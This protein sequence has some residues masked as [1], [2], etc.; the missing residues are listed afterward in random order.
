V[1]FFTEENIYCKLVVT[2]LKKCTI[3]SNNQRDH[4][5]EDL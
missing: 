5:N 1:D 2:N 4:N 3:P